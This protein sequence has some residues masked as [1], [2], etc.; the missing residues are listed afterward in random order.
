[1]VYMASDLKETPN[2]YLTQQTQTAYI[3]Q[4]ENVLRRGRR[5]TLQVFF[6]VT[7]KR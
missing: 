3:L 5:G 4:A 2:K 1:M 6:K 7:E